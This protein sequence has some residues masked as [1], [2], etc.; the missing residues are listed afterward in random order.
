[1]VSNQFKITVKPPDIDQ[2]NFDP[3][4][5]ISTAIIP[6][7]IGVQHRLDVNKFKMVT[8]PTRTEVENIYKLT[9]NNADPI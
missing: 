5:S 1:M 8:S 4:D 6:V 2:I 7:P 9:T 3:I